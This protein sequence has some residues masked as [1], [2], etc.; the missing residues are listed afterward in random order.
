M[1]RFLPA[2]LVLSALLS[3]SGC[4][5]T[6]D[7][8]PKKARYPWIHTHAFMWDQAKETLLA[9]WRIASED[10]ALDELLTE[11]DTQLSPMNTFGRRNRLRV[12]IVEV[13]G[14][15]FEVSATQESEMNTNQTNPLS[16]EEASW[17][18]ASND[19]GFAVQFLV[20]LERRLTPPRRWEENEAR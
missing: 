20:D 14:K 17:K 11:W 15:S 13:E 2:L 4:Q 12:K 8:E 1:S 16:L 18:E 19:G 7:N 6:P 9:K 10:R 5:S 3:A